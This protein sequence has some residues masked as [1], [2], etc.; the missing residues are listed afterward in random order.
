MEQV[1]GPLYWPLGLRLF[2][3][4]IGVPRLRIPPHRTTSGE[5]LSSPFLRTLYAL[6]MIGLLPFPS[7]DNNLG[8]S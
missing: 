8:S 4:E 7:L 6:L 3:L 5:F 1:L 2:P